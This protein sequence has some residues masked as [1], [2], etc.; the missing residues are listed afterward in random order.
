ML[1]GRHVPPGT[2]YSNYTIEA[3][4]GTFVNATLADLIEIVPYSSSSS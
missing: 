2:F 4:H 3:F 1:S